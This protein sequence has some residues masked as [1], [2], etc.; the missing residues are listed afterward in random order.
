MNMFDFLKEKYEV[1]FWITYEGHHNLNQGVTIEIRANSEDEALVK[2]EEIIR[3]RY[4]YV[5]INDVYINGQHTSL[6]R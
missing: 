4:K 5:K 2:A 1:S 6:V 3:N